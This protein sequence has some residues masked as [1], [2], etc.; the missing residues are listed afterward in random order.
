MKNYIITL[1]IYVGISSLS[2]AVWAN[3]EESDESISTI[4]NIMSEKV[5]I[6]T[7]RLLGK[8][9]NQVISVYGKTTLGIEQQF[10]VSARY[11]G[12]I[13]AINYTIGDTVKKGDLL[14]VIESNESLNTYEVR[15]PI[16]GLILQRN[17]NVGATTQGITLF[18]IANVDNLWAE[19]KVFSTHFNKV[20]VGQIIEIEG[21]EQVFT[22]TIS[23]IIPTKEQPF[24]IVRTR[25][26]NT[27]H[28]LVSGQLLKG[29]IT[30]NKFDVDLAIEKLALQELG[31]RLGVFVK[32]GDEYE[33]TPLTLGRSDKN[34][35]EVIEGLDRGSEYVNKNSFLIKADI[36]KSEVEDDD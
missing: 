24:I 31:G 13:K 9:L 15:S 2:I 29:D 18:D 27:G 11:N 32:E 26:D 33:F 19:F 23:R 8:K 5:G 1:F 16:S 4:E 6:E 10:Q 25:L 20:K 30:I 22:S 14:A 12:V 3:D 34:Y 36:L 21:G 17:G 35:I 7:T 28:N